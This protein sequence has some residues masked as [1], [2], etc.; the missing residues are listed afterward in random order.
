M[1]RVFSQEE[2]EQD[3][4]KWRDQR[5]FTAHKYAMWKR[6]EKFPSQ[7]PNSLMRCICGVTFDSHKTNE[8]YDHR[9][10]I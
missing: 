9:G 6:G 4:Q 1:A 10:H 7:T 8:S 5:D 3:Y 2:C